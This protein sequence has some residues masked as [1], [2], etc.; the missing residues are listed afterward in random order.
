MRQ[1]WRRLRDI[2][3]ESRLLSALILGFIVGYAV[4]AY[5]LFRRGLEFAGQ[6]PG[7]GDLLIERLLYLLF[8]CLFI[9]LLFSN[10]VIG[11]ANLFRNRETHFLLSLPIPFQTVF[12]WKFL[13]ST[14]LASWAFLF[15]VA[16]MLVAFGLSQDAPWQFYVLGPLLIALFI[17][18]PAVLGAWCA[19][20]LARFMDRRSFQTIALLVCGIL[21]V[22]G[23][24][25]LKKAPI[26]DPML[27]TRVLN[28]LDQ[29]L[30]KTEFTQFPFLPSYWVATSLL[31]GIEGA[32][33]TALFF[34][35]VLLSYVLL[36]GF[37]AFTRMGNL[38]YGACSIV[39]SRVYVLGQWAW[40]RSWRRQRTD[41]MAIR[42][43]AERFFGGL[44]WL[45][46]DVKALLVKDFRMFWRDTTQWGQ[47]LVLFGLLGVYIFNLRHFSHQLTNPFWVHLVSYLN[48]GA[49]S[50]NLATLTTRFVFPQFSLEGKRMWLVGMSPLGLRQIVRVKYWLATGA[51]LAVTVSLMSGS[52]YMLKIPAWK[53]L[54]FVGAITVMTLTLNGL[55][56]G[57][58]VLYPNFKVDNPSKIV[59]SFGGTF[60]LVLSF[61]YIVGSVASLGL[62][63]PWTGSGN[64]SLLRICI[65]WASFGGLS[66][67][68]GWIPYRYGLR[69]L[70][71]LEL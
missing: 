23:R 6:F 10:L 54:Y 21:V 50:L 61:L 12:Q 37:L 42:G 62:G 60:C 27:E 46:I 68:L 36:L 47:T 55:A 15:L 35:L 31:N 1:N 14:F 26:T 11:Y 41:V 53:G 16:P 66:V 70:Q 7:L 5:W 30:S 64:A 57:L 28:V 48:L 22:L 40:F 24:F 39:Q 67:L 4:L 34:V 8:A 20:N 19:V 2:P 59:S 51:S 58:G 18:L 3:H 9:L 52:C 69:R 44:W 17:V 45:P 13:E 29:L 63:S 32:V 65:G 49:C 43:P 71:H 56:V 38:F 33:R 25:W